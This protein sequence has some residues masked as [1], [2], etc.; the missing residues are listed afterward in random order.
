[1][2]GDTNLFLSEQSKHAEVRAPFYM[3]PILYI[4]DRLLLCDRDVDMESISN[5]EYGFMWG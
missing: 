5:L 1:M 2:V 4:V 3:R